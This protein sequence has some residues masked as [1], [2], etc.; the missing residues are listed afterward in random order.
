MCP[1]GLI[2][3]PRLTPVRGQVLPEYYLRIFLKA[4]LTTRSLETAPKSLLLS[5]FDDPN[6]IEHPDI[7]DGEPIFPFVA[8]RIM[9]NMTK[10]QR[11]AVGLAPLQARNLPCKLRKEP[12]QTWTTW[13]T[14]FDMD[15]GQR[16]RAFREDLTSMMVRHATAGTDTE[17]PTWAPK[18]DTSYR[19]VHNAYTMSHGTVQR[20]ITDYVDSDKDCWFAT[21]GLREPGRTN[22]DGTRFSHR[23]TIESMQVYECLKRT[24]P[25]TNDLSRM[26]R[27]YDN[28]AIF[29]RHRQRR[30]A[31]EDMRPSTYYARTAFN[32]YRTAQSEAKLNIEP[33]FVVLKAETSQEFPESSRPSIG[34]KGLSPLDDEKSNLALTY[35]LIDLAYSEFVRRAGFRRLPGSNG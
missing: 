24:N 20:A 14:C 28:Y 15:P 8:Q 7:Y 4:G 9:M 13:D 29:G 11:K 26:E 34:N 18:I 31:M 32:M 22:N 17:T 2:L 35:R 3:W 21:L 33:T 1:D 12:I 5:I 30:V 25:S 16:N 19:A 6:V 10:S 23:L 27:V